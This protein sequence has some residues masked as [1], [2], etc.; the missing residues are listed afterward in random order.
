MLD[1]GK[2]RGFL[3][4]QRIENAHSAVSRSRVVFKL[5]GKKE[6]VWFC[7]VVRTE[8]RRKNNKK[9]DTTTSGPDH[10]HFQLASEYRGFQ[11]SQC[12]QQRGTRNRKKVSFCLVQSCD[13]PSCA[14]ASVQTPAGRIHIQIT[15]YLKGSGFTSELNHFLKIH[16][17]G[18]SFR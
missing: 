10:T 2:G 8:L 14:A 17:M 13:V 5:E 9:D 18:V 11:C 4:A 6:G 16:G 3:L 15:K 12:Y 1:G 7:V